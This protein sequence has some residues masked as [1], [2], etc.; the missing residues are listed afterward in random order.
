MHP[1]R[2]IA[3]CFHPASARAGEKSP[4]SW[5]VTSIFLSS[6][7]LAARKLAI[8][9]AARYLTR[10]GAPRARAA[11][12]G[13]FLG[14]RVRIFG[15]NS[16]YAAG[17]AI[18]TSE[19]GGYAGPIL[20]HFG[21]EGGVSRPGYAD[22]GVL[23]RV[24]DEPSLSLSLTHSHTHTHTHIEHRFQSWPDVVDYPLILLSNS[25]IP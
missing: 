23:G 13:A 15:V 10:R 14:P 8:L 5:L 21:A 2:K 1:L 24:G 9:D 7:L 6:G 18:K 25:T 12:G 3:G 16:E 17:Y 20:G 22:A 19:I 4:A 11:P